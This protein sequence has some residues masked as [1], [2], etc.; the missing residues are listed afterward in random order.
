M[1]TWMIA[2]LRRQGEAFRRQGY[3]GHNRR[4]MR[5]SMKD[6]RH[7]R[8]RRRYRAYLAIWRGAPVRV[9]PRAV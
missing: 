6:L 1:E 3:D 7:R 2:D 4:T 8:I 9:L 5:T